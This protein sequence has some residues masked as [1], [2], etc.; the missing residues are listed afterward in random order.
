VV[1]TR[2]AAPPL[3]AGDRDGERPAGGPLAVPVRSVSGAGDCFTAFLALGLAHGLPLA[4]AAGLAH[5]AGG[6]YV[7]RPYNTPPL[8]C[9]VLGVL[10]PAAGKVL[11]AAELAEALDARHGGG[12]VVLAPG[13]FDLLHAGHAAMLRWARLQ[14]DCLVA[15]L[16]DDAS[17]ARL[18]GAGRPVLPLAQRQALLAAL[19]CVDYVVS[20]AED[21]PAAL[22][23]ALAGRVRVVV[24]GPDWA[25]RLARTPESWL[26]PEVLAA[27]AD[28]AATL[29]TSDLLRRVGG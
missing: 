19:A 24:K 20:F 26:V 13:C 2:G 4:E 21:S 1:V 10:D 9:E 28:P 6:A 16:N 18:K 11:T 15:A 17:V 5:L 3:I 14:G 22:L 27:P 8:P 23:E 7:G 12:R 29:H 25:A